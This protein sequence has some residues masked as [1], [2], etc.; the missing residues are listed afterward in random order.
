MKRYGKRVAA[1]LIFLLLCLVSASAEEMLF[2]Y[3]AQT[4][5][6]AVNL[7][8]TMDTSGKAVG[9]ILRGETVTVLCACQNGRAEEW[10][11]VQ[12]ADE[13]LGY[14]RSDLLQPAE[15]MQAELAAFAGKASTEEKTAYIGN[16]KTKKF[17]LPSCRTLPKES[18]Q[19]NFDTREEAI[20]KGY[21]P[22]G[23][24]K[25]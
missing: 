17:H 2:P 5:E 14:V 6:L 16:R 8:A 23:N 10:L 18:N 13:T 3:S 12:L 20:N 9:K 19:V 21:D 11:V 25:P 4:G 7:R 24:C 15:A 1:M 22:C